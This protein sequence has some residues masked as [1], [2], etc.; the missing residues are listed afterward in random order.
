MTGS[1][2]LTSRDA[3]AY[4]ASRL[5]RH[6]AEFGPAP[7]LAEAGPEARLVLMAGETVILRTDPEQTGTALLGPD[8]AERAGARAVEIFLGRVEG[9]P[10]FAGAVAEEATSLFPAPGYRALDLRALAAEGAVAREEQGL[11]ATAKSLLAWHARH[12]FCGNCGSPTAIAAGGFR[13]ECGACGL[14]HF[15][16][17]DPV[18]IMLVRRGDACLLGRGRHFKPGM[19]SCLAGF[20]EPGETVEDAVR[21]ETREETGIAVGAVAYHASQPWPFP[22]SLMLGCVAEG[23]TEDVRTD[24]DELEDARWFPRA[25]V[26]QM[27]AGTHPEGLTVP[28]PTAI[29]HLLLRDWVDGVIAAPPAPQG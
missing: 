27:I 1:P 29:A 21:R 19:Y 8:E 16:R 2:D 5:V 6:S 13:R 22:A 28:P 4:A 10:V 17:T 12:R 15:P 14:H 23:L 26:V 18:A 9:W 3:L 20:I 7:V 24:P 25:E 11:I